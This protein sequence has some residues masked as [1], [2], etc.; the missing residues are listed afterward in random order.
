MDSFGHFDTDGIWIAEN[1]AAFKNYLARNANKRTV[2]KCKL[3][4]KQRSNPQNAYYWGVV[5]PMIADEL[6][7]DIDEIHDLMK[8]KFNKQVRQGT[9]GEMALPGST[10]KLT[11]TEFEEYLERI[12]VWA[13]TE[14]GIK[15]PLPNETIL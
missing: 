4:R 10:T 14:F 1:K 5:L 11:T 9:R 15:I 12:R 7:Y 6:G 8:L 3:Y 13:I 2:L